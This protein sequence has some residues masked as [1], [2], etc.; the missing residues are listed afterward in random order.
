VREVV[1]LIVKD[2]IKSGE[3]REVDPNVFMW[4][5]NGALNFVLEEQLC[6]RSP[7]IEL[8]G[9]SRILDLIFDGLTNAKSKKKR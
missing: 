7:Q 4:A 3:F 8:K 9:L 2:G 1:G 5:L 6:H